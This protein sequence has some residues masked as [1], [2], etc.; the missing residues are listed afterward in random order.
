MDGFADYVA[1][2]WG[3]AESLRAVVAY[4]A[5]ASSETRDG[6][7]GAIQRLLDAGATAGTVRDDVRAADVFAS[8]TGIF[9]V[10]EA[11]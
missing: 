1:A 10:S 9:L 8:L 2:K 7:I 11:P 4:G 6:L 5:I 3:M